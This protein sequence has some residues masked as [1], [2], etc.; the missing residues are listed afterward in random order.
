MTTYICYGSIQEPFSGKSKDNQGITDFLE[1]IEAQAGVE[2]RQ[3]ETRKEKLQ[4][5]LFRTHLRGDARDMMNMLTPTERESWTQAKTLYIAK[6]K[7]ER[8]KR[9]KQR[10]REAMASFRQRSD[11]S[12][13]AYGER[14]VRLRQLIDV[15]DEGFLVSRF[16]RGVRDRNIRQMIAVGQEDMS[17]LTVAQVNQRIMNLSGAGND[18]D[19]EEDRGNSGDNSEQSSN[20]G[21]YKKHRKR[22]SRGK[23]SEEKKAIKAAQK[24]I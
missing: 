4:L 11:E 16:L 8:D 6:Y 17:K 19:S 5:R 2:C 12:L 18:S 14:A 23:A 1:A 21:L 10:A 22:S 13:R 20:D 7:T 3:D 15:A 9:A 24:K